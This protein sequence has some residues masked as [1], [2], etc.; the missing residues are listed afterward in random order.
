VGLLGHSIGL[1]LEW[2]AFIIITKY[3]TLLVETHVT[4]VQKETDER[5]Q[6]FLMM[7]RKYSGTFLNLTRIN[8]SCIKSVL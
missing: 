4:T 6:A 2:L 1:F 3:I 5:F 7:V 8:Y